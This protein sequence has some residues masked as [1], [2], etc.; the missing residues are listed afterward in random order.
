MVHLFAGLG[1]DE[2]SDGAEVVVVGSVQHSEQRLLSPT[3]LDRR[4]HLFPVLLPRTQLGGGL[5]ARVA[6]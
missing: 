1:A 3:P 6:L 5:T 2:A 4:F